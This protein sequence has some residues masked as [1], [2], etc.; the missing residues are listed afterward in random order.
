[1]TELEALLDQILGRDQAHAGT[2]VDG[3]A[4]AALTDTGLTRVGIPEAL[5]GSGGTVADA[6]TVTV[7]IAQ[8]GLT[9]PLSLFAIA[10]WATRT[11]TSI[12]DTQVTAPEEASRLLAAFGSSCRLLGAQRSCLRLTREHVL[13]RQQFG[14]PLAAHQVVRHTVAHMLADVAAVESAVAHAA[15][16]LPTPGV[17]PAPAAAIAVAAATVQAAT[18]ATRVARAAHQLHGAIGMSEEHPLHHYT[19]PLWTWRDENGSATEWAT[20]LARLVQ[21]HYAADLWAALTDQS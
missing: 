21:T 5:G 2:G 20:Y 9:V 13:T 11:G 19:T 6:V 12:P 16:L 17:D 1:M 14:R 7:R 10:D 15:R 8:A 18:S 4:W 3:T